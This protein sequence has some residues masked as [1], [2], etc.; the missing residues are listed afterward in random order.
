MKIFLRQIL[1]RKNISVSELSKLSG[2][3]RTTLSELANTRVLPDKTKIETI[4][5]L[6]NTLN[7]ATSEL[8]AEKSP[9]IS[10]ISISKTNVGYDTGYNA[11]F[12][13]SV[14]ANLS[15]KLSY[16]VKT[17]INTE[18]SSF[19]FYWY[20]QPGANIKIIKQ[21]TVKP[22]RVITSLVDPLF[23]SEDNFK[24]FNKHYSL[25]PINYGAP[26]KAISQSIK[27]I[28]TEKQLHYVLQIANFNCFAKELLNYLK[29]NEKLFYKD[30]D[31]YLEYAILSGKKIFPKDLITELDNEMFSEKVRPFEIDSIEWD[32]PI[33]LNDNQDNEEQFILKSLDPIRNF[34]RIF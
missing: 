2:I 14:F 1:D 20:I 18:N 26:L 17:I 29:K 34:T 25:L 23:T 15:V 10:K 32:K 13:T 16:I 30:D 11:D 24:L 12:S 7:V 28:N 22:D 4:S 21:D 5:R 31:V 6:C 33:T 27:S 19:D 3:G 8:I 9:Y